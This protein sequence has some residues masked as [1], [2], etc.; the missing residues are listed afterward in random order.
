MVQIS[1][2]PRICLL[3]MDID[4][5]F[6]EDNKKSQRL[7][8]VCKAEGTRCIDQQKITFIFEL[9]LKLM[10]EIMDLFMYKQVKALLDSSIIRMCSLPSDL[11]SRI[12]NSAAHGIYS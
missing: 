1:V 3:V 6:T 12:K 4:V 2:R 7:E 9:I 11:N 10:L 5:Y 8:V